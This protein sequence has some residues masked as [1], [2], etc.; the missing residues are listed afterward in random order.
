[1]KKYL[2]A[3]FSVL[4]GTI[5]AN[6]E[7]FNI[8][9]PFQQSYSLAP[10]AIDTYN[11]YLKKNEGLLARMNI[12]TGF[13]SDCGAHIQLASYDHNGEVL[14]YKKDDV[15]R[16]YG[17]SSP[18]YMGAAVIAEA[19]GFH[20]INVI[21]EDYST[22]GAACLYTAFPYGI[23]IVKFTGN[24][25]PTKSIKATS[26]IYSDLL[27][28]LDSHEYTFNGVKGK[29]LNANMI[30]NTGFDDFC[31]SST[32]LELYKKG[33]ANPVSSTTEY[34]VGP[35][36]N[37]NGSSTIKYKF[38]DSSQYRLIIRRHFLEDDH[39]KCDDSQYK[40]EL[41]LNIPK[42]QKSANKK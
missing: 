4:V 29:K 3:M 17:T 25:A 6:A 10:G 37:D 40:Y 23:S 35:E 22:A 34:I 14:L 31:G 32:S 28:F 41:E 1:M 27:S 24:A 19:D 21:R 5:Y 39:T 42:P 11:V 36:G 18:S 8:N 30:V 38:A 13:G 16:L 12:S 7:N 26:G 20:K 2:L 15:F 9:V 33:R